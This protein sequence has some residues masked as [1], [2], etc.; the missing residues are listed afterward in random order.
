M[1]LSEGPPLKPPELSSFFRLPGLARL[2]AAAFVGVALALVLGSWAVQPHTRFLAAWDAAVATYL[3]LAWTVVHALD[4]RETRARVESHDASG[5]VVLILVLLAACV[6]LAAITWGLREMAGLHGSTRTVRVALTILALAGSWLMIH[7]VFAFHYARAY[8][9]PQASGQ[10]TGGL[11]FPG[12]T[13][14]DYLDFLYYACVIGMTSQVAD[15]AVSSRAMRRLTLV[16]SVAAFAFNLVILALG[17]N[18]V[19]AAVQ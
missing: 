1:M 3:A 4:A 11:R 2:S 10:P 14:P 5:Y 6:S 7:T 8:Y 13:Q 18:L 12:G 19:G 16:H 9:Q 15:V 17:V